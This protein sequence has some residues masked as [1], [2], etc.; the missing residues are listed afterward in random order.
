MSVSNVKLVRVGCNITARTLVT[1]LQHFTVFDL[2]FGSDPLEGIQTPPWDETKVPTMN[3]G[4][5]LGS[6]WTGLA[7]F[8][9][10]IVNG[11][12][13]AAMTMFNVWVGFCDTVFTT[14]GFPN[15]ADTYRR[16]LTDSISFLIDALGYSFQLLTMFFSFLTE[17]FGKIYTIL[18]MAFT[19]W[20]SMLTYF[21]AFLG[22][23]YTS[24]VNIWV[25]YNIPQWI[26]LGLI[27]YP[28]YLVFLWE[29]EGLGAVIDQLT[30]L[31]NVLHGTV[32][33]LLTI[34]E[35]IWA[36]ISRLL[37]AIPVVE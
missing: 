13:W 25:D 14:M 3:Q 21:T 34:A 1:K 2:T 26:T 32:Y 6:I 33:L 36:G 22:G 20:M 16:W 7:W 17:Y 23:T 15:V 29:E 24:G 35:Y 18:N 30:F 12:T 4:G 27:L 9:V 5:L 10:Q 19:T 31:Y 37:E 28:I 11:V 8:A